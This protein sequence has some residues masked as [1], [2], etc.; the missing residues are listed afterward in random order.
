MTCCPGSIKLTQLMLLVKD[1]KPICSEC[2]RTAVKAENLCSPKKLSESEFQSS[3]SWQGL[4]KAV[5]AT[6]LLGRRGGV[7]RAQRQRQFFDI[8]EER[9]RL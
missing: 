5:Q 2:G 9:L 8:S 4:P 1:P 3:G 7:S 6:G